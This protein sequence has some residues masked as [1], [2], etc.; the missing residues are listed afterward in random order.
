MAI[1]PTPASLPAW[2]PQGMADWAPLVAAAA[3]I[4]IIA[5][6]LMTGAEITAKAVPNQDQEERAT[7][8][9]AL[10]PLNPGTPALSTQRVGTLRLVPTTQLPSVKQPL[11]ADVQCIRSAPSNPSPQAEAAVAAGWHV[12]ADTMVHG[13][14]FVMVDAGAEKG[15]AGCA[16]IGASALVFNAHGLIAIAYDRNGKQSSRLGSL[17]VPRPGVLQLVALK[18]PLAELIVSDQEI[19]LKPVTAGIRNRASQ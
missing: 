17:I 4:F 9:S 15:P 14:Q 7:A 5:M 6:A 12:S 16:A 19:G 10:P 3:T 2:A 11:R 1:P 18:G 13:F 8:A